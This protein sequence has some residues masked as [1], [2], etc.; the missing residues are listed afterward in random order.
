MTRL[1][2]PQIAAAMALV[3]MTQEQL[4]AMAGIGRNTLN[5]TINDSASTKEETLAVIRRTLE[6]QG[7]EFIDHQGVRLKP[8]NLEVF[9]GREGFMNFLGIIHRHLE[10]YGGE[11]CV[12]GVNEDLFLKY[13]R[14]FAQIHMDRMAEIIKENKTIKMRILIAEGDYNFISSNYAAYR[15]QPKQYFSPTAFYVFGDHLALISFTN[16]P[17]PLV[18]VIHSAAFANAYKNSF[19]VSWMSAIEPP[20]RG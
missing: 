1:S 16:D 20:A 15:W 4:A 10:A 9:E 19:D 6:S 2:G 3:N 18:I 12:S 17:A 13:Q 7:V 11:V 5:R 8:H 14:D